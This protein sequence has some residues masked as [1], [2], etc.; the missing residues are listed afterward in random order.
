MDGVAIGRITIVQEDRFRL[1]DAAGRGY[2]FITGKRV[3]SAEQL[4][5]WRQN[6]VSVQVRFT[7]HPDRGAVARRITPAGND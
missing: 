3:A 2:L 1:I 7:G 4:D 6:G 5:R